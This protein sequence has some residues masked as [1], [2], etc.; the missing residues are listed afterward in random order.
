[1]TSSYFQK[2]IGMSIKQEY[3][4]DENGEVFSPITSVGSTYNDMGNDLSPSFMVATFSGDKV[5]NISAAWTNYQL[6]ME[7][8]TQSKGDSFSLKNGDIYIN[9]NVSYVLVSSLVGFWGT[10]STMELTSSICLFRNGKLIASCASDSTKNDGLQSRAVSPIIFQV[11]Q[12]DFIR[13]MI[14]S[15]ATGE[16][17]IIGRLKNT[18]VTVLKL[19]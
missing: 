14:N 3:L 7:T 17:N 11:Q 12:G 19:C 6:P 5:V 18:Y 16:Y 9:K 10:P 15:G 4:R 2:G 13:I 8:T 1:M